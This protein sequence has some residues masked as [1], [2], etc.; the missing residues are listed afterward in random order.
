MEAVVTPLLQEEGLG[1]ILGQVTEIPTSTIEQIPEFLSPTQKQIAP[2]TGAGVK[3]GSSG[4]SYLGFGLLV[5]GAGGLVVL[6]KSGKIK[7]LRG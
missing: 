4:G 6:A 7:L 1:K 2:V 3:T 5:L